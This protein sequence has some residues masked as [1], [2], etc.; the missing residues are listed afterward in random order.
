MEVERQRRVED[1]R[2]SN[3]EERASPDRIARPGDG[4]ILAQP[5]K[6]VKVEQAHDKNCA[7]KIAGLTQI[8]GDELRRIQEVNVHLEHEREMLRRSMVGT[9]HSQ[10][11]L[12]ATSFS[13]AMSDPSPYSVHLPPP[14]QPFYPQ[15]RAMVSL[16]NV[17]AANI[18]INE[19][20]PPPP[21]PPSVIHNVNSGN[22]S[23]VS[24]SN[25]NNNKGKCVYSSP[26]LRYSVL[27]CAHTQLVENARLNH[28]WLRIVF[29]S[30]L[31]TGHF[32]L[33]YPV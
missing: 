14:L 32:F 16:Q 1:E 11:N 20:F 27:T 5:T 22:V 8:Q 19:S 25:V 31:S 12:S 29:N 30:L 4:T 23:S 17:S 15:L 7:L 18:S 33:V 24:L 13:G 2:P 10:S 21:P 6:L 28:A 3:P 9:P 26:F